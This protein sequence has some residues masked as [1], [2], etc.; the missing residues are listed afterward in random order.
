MADFVRYFR[1]APADY[2]ALTRPEDM[3]LEARMKAE[4]KARAAAINKAK[5]KRR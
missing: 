3:A 4:R 5:Q 1:F 2:W